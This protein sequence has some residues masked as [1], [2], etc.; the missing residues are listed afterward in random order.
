MI[1]CFRTPYSHNAKDIW[2]F[3]T[4]QYPPLGIFNKKWIY[5]SFDTMSIK[6]LSVKAKIY[7]V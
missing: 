6:Y 3:I 2:D 4:K 7:S 1:F 5:L